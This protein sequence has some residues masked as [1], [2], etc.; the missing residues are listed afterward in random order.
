MVNIT[1]KYKNYS[2]IM[3]VNCLFVNLVESKKKKSKDVN[4]Y[5]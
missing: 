4:T 2:G 5:I 1:K 3:Q